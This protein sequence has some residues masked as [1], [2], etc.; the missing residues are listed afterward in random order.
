M[1]THRT[2][3]CLASFANKYFQN[4]NFEGWVFVNFSQSLVAIFKWFVFSARV[5]LPLIGSEDAM[6]KIHKLL[7]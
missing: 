1:R 7:K 2:S 3:G 4:M 6:W 5:L